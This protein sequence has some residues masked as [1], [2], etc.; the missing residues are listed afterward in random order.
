VDNGYWGRDHG[1][2]EGIGPDNSL[3]TTW[4]VYPAGGAFDANQ[5]T[6]VGQSS[7]RVSGAGGNGINPI[8]LSSFTNFLKAE[9]ALILGTPGDPQVLL[10]AGVDASLNKVA[11]FPASI[12]YSIPT[13]DTTLVMTSLTQQKYKGI[14]QNLY[15][16]ASTTDAK[17]NVIEKEYYLAAWGNGIEPYNNYRRTGKPDNMQPMLGNSPGLFIRTYFYASVYVNYNKNAVQKTV[18]N[19]KAFWD[20]NP[21]N[22]VY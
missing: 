12:G 3:R 1:N 11:N 9:A 21:D 17:L 6:A 10:L 20:T 16:N 2:S 13:A 8:W 4:G 5:N 18:T 19:I 14:V 7:K 22:F 15:Q